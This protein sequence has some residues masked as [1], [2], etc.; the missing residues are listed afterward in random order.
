MNIGK[1]TYLNCGERNQDMID[2]HSCIHI[3]KQLWNK[4]LKGIN[5]F[6][7]R[8]NIIMIFHVFTCILTIC[9]HI[10]NS[11]HYQLPVGRTFHWYCGGH[12][13]IRIPLKPEFCI[14]ALISQLLKLCTYMYL[15]WSIRPSTLSF[16]LVPGSR[17]VMGL[18]TE[19]VVL[20]DPWWLA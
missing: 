10:T 11:Q 19:R 18:N 3:N 4:R 12:G 13:L 7:Y 1:I 6:L 5:L 16:L 9:G 20:T 15:R 2:R 17:M 14:H 8:S